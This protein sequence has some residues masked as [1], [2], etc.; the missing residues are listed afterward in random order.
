[1]QLA[2]KGKF[3]ADSSRWDWTLGSLQ[4]RA[5]SHSGRT[6]KST[7][8]MEGEASPVKSF[9]T[10]TCSTGGLLILLLMA[11]LID[12]GATS[13][14]PHHPVNITWVVYNPE[15]GRLL[16]SSSNVA[17]KGTWW[18]E[19]TLDLCVLA[20]DNNGFHGRSQLSDF[21]G[22]P[23]FETLVLLTGPSRGTHH[24]Q[25]Q[26]PSMSVWREEG[27]GTKLQDVGELILFI[28]PLGDVKL[29]ER[30]IGSPI[31][32]KTSFR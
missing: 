20:A 18:P 1:M 8:R 24:A 26:H 9:E 11:A 10:E 13:H 22:S 7:S 15:T 6:G 3:I 14:N 12:P 29:Q 21:I 17:P 2:K 27:I 25:N 32:S 31:P 4:S 19:L 23:Q 16:N 30:S 28:V 5:A